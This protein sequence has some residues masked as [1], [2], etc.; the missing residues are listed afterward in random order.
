MK[1]P[2]RYLFCGGGFKQGCGTLQHFACRFASKSQK[3]N[4]TWILPEFNEIGNTI[5]QYLCLACSCAGNHEYGP[6][7]RSDDLKLVWIKVSLVVNFENAALGFS[8]CACLYRVCFCRADVKIFT[9]GI[10]RLCHYK[11]LLLKVM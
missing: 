5:N 6:V 7:N 4:G 10:Y 8:H 9:L 2:A 3:Q 1:C 11:F